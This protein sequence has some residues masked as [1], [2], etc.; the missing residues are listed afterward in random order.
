M[1]FELGKW[2]VICDRC[3]FQRKNDEVIKTW[4]SFIVCKPEVKTGCFEHRHPLD[5][6]RST[7]DDMSVP[8]T[9]PSQTETF[10]TGVTYVAVSVGTQDTTIPS[11]NSGNG[12]TL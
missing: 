8:F 12:T 5:F 3:G 1:N 9:R 10:V 11:G 2:L 7:P 6:I 4:D